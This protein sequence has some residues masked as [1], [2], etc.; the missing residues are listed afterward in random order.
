MRNVSRKLRTE[1]GI[2]RAAGILLLCALVFTSLV[3]GTGQAHS[4]LPTVSGAPPQPLEEVVVRWLVRLTMT[5]GLVVL[6]CKATEW[7]LSETARSLQEILRTISTTRQIAVG[8]KRSKRAGKRHVRRQHNRA[9]DV[10]VKRQAS[11]T[12]LQNGSANEQA[13]TTPT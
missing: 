1:V 9:P 2:S 4:Q 12:G 3:Y 6:V 7:A 5:L 13:S 10:R 11:D 8:L